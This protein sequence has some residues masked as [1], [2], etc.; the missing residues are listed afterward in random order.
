M[1]FTSRARQILMILLESGKPIPE[2]Q[3]ADS[4]GVSKR[5]VQ[6]EAE[7][8]GSDLL[9]YHLELKRKKSAGVYLEGD[10]V[11]L[12]KLKEDLKQSAGTEI[13]DKNLRRKY[14]IA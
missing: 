7:Y 8:L 5:T 9:S 1:E 3:I 12:L 14:L 6:R 4:I 13:T 10:S 2:Q 11:D